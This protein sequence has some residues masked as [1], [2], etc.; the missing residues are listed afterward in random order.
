MLL[1]GL[2]CYQQLK[3]AEI[4]EPY[5][6]ER[7]RPHLGHLLLHQKAKVQEALSLAFDSHAGQ[8]RKSGEPFI[9]HPVEV[10]CILAKLHMDYESIIAGL[11][12]DTVED[13][14]SVSFDEIEVRYKLGMPQRASF[15][16]HMS[17]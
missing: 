9:T 16:L 2:Q 7:L 3:T 1:W 6:W 4:D 5:L 15:Q 13:C 17:L 12:H 11:L 14:D 10:A 8:I